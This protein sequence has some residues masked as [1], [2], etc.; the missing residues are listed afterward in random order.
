MDLVAAH[1]LTTSQGRLQ[2]VPMLLPG[3][4]GWALGL[5]EYGILDLREEKEGLGR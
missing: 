2:I 4:Q 1:S 5:A 3:R